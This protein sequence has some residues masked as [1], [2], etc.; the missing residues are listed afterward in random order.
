MNKKILTHFFLTVITVVIMFP[1]L[2]IAE[3][4]GGMGSGSDIGGM[5]SGNGTSGGQTVTQKIN[6]INP[7]KCG[8]QIECSIPGLLKAIIKNILLPIGG[9]VAAIMIMYAGF[10]FVTARGEPAKITQAKTAL[11]YAVIGTAILL[12]AWT[13]SEAIQG[14]IKQIST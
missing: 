1:I 8:G 2:A 14:T 3:D 9:V 13:I 12:G 6:I 7:F 10:L 4:I 11:L 5:G